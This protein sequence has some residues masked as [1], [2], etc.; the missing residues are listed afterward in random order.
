MRAKVDARIDRREHKKPS[1]GREP[2]PGGKA[3]QRLF[4]Y[5]GQR[6]PELNRE[7]V[8]TLP[9]PKGARPRFGPAKPAVPAAKGTDMAGRRPVQAQPSVSASKSYAAA[10]IKAAR[11]LTKT[12][13]RPTAARGGTRRAAAEAAAAA[14]TQWQSIGPTVIPNGQTYG[15][16]RV[17][18]VGRVSAIAVDPSDPK[19]L[20]L[21]AAGGGIWESKDTGATWTPCTD[22]M[23]SLAIGAV[24]F[25]PA[26][27][28][29]VYAGSGEG[30]FYSI[31]APG[32]I[33][34]RTVEALG[35]WQRRRPLLAAD[36]SISSWTRRSLLR[37]T[38]RP[39][40]AC[41]GPIT[42]ARHGA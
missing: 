7:V 22:Q 9:L 23:P 17:D 41:L 26:N 10:I 24:A 28:K 19:H 3:L 15:T 20:V 30:N 27:P 31:W 34:P 11:G 4:N 32:S 8:A 1:K 12:P 42:R 40:M 39:P 5:L 25:D 18:V 14:P 29:Q 6:D 37:S 38:L 33:S 2:R 35:Q 21:G 16:S 13:A 36:F